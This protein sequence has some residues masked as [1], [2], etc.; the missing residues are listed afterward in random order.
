MEVAT[1]EL[2]EKLYLTPH[3]LLHWH[4]IRPLGSTEPANQLVTFIQ[5]SREGLTVL[6]TVVK[7]C[8][9]TICIVWASL[10]NDAGPHGQANALKTP[11]HENE[12]G[13]TIILL[14]IQKSSQ[15][16]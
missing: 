9:R 13:W 11:T 2:A 4:E 12:K 15:N 1:L 3:E 5:E 6:D 16:L 8:L 14:H 10:R 7:V